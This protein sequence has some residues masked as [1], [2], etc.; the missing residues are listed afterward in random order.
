MSAH[1]SG[2]PTAP[3]PA[4]PA[5]P[6]R[7]SWE[8]AA[9][10]GRPTPAPAARPVPASQPSAAPAP[11]A[12]APPRYAP[13]QPAPPQHAPPPQFSPPQATTHDATVAYDLAGN[14]LPSS[15]PAPSPY[16]QPHVAGHGTPYPP[17]APYGYAPAPAA[18]VWPPQP[19]GASYGGRNNSGEQSHLPPEIQ[20]L[21]WHWGAFFFPVLWTKNHGLTTFAAL[22]AGGFFAL[23]I[24]RMVLQS[25][26]PLAYLGICVVY[27][28]TYFAV[29]LYFGFNGHRI[30][31][32]NR[33]F[34]GGLAEYFKVQNAWMWWGLGINVVLILPSLIFLVLMG[35]GLAATASQPS[36][37]GS[38]SS[39]GSGYSSPPTSSDTSGGVPTGASSSGGSSSG[40]SDNS[41]GDGRVGGAGFS[42]P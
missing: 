1:P 5:R 23:R 3:N 37:G 27:G 19:G 13:P 12:A 39:Y 14:P 28:I 18:G 42:T 41:S 29:Q 25:I 36:Y 6:L 34:Q 20:R 32:R 15:A 8:V 10:T 22:I 4:A 40:P 9:E 2:D 21:R 26:S 30:A 11:Q 35:I 31:W 33:H 24:I 38:G 7:P 16:A 17:P